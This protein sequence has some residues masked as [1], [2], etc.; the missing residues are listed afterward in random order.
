MVEFLETH[1]LPKLNKR[2]KKNLT[3]Q[4]TTNEVKKKYYKNL[5][6]NKILEKMAP[7][8]NLT[9]HLKNKDIS[10]SNYS[11]IQEKERL[12]SWGQHYLNFKTVLRHCKER[13]F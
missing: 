7:Q 4:I 5:P 2:E 11:T 6:T 12:I 9:K 1:N 8:V 13:R 3:R 10:F